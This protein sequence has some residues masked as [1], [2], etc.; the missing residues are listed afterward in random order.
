MSKG[1][2]RATLGQVFW[3]LSSGG[4][5]FLPLSCQSLLDPRVFSL[6]HLG[7]SPDS[8]LLPCAVGGEGH[9]PPYLQVPQHLKRLS[10]NLIFLP[11]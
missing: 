7:G 1:R 4:P 6:Y 9:P 3:V 11:H 5:A 2:D 8:A 10:E